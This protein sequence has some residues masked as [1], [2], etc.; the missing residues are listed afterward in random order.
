MHRCA[1]GESAPASACAGAPSACECGQAKAI[2][3]RLPWLIDW[4]RQTVSDGDEADARSLLPPSVRAYLED[5]GGTGDTR[6]GVDSSDSERV[7]SP[8]GG[9]ADDPLSDPRGSDDDDDE[10]S[11]Q[12]E[13][14]AFLDFIGWK[15]GVLSDI[16]TQMGG[17][18]TDGTVS[19]ESTTSSP[20]CGQS[21]SI[22][23]WR[24]SELSSV[25]SIDLGTSIAFPDGFL[26][27]TVP[28][29]YTPSRSKKEMRQFCLPEWED[30]V[31]SYGMPWSD[32]DSMITRVG[33]RQ[34]A[35]GLY[36]DE[37][38]VGAV[39]YAIQTLVAFPSIIDRIPAAFLAKSSVSSGD[40]RED[41][42]S[43]V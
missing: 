27:M 32:A 4:Y 2:A 5:G 6:E 20:S 12:S 25:C 15:E 3:L 29:G 8:D 28:D 10:T 36:F 18:G 39:R 38:Y 21:G 30:H 17:G 26:R 13:I 16:L 24:V 19:D 23:M 34:S 1:C 37:F 43:V 11:I 41:R 22:S 35:P 9:A 33:T 31:S 7:A 40:L 14:D 42:K